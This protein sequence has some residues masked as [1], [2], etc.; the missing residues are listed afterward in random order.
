MIISLN[1]VTHSLKA[2][3][4]SGESDRASTGNDYKFVDLLQKPTVFELLKAIAK[5]QEQNYEVIRSYN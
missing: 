1:W 2:T 5:V 4:W 3:L